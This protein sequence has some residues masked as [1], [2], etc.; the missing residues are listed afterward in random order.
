MT[1]CPIQGRERSSY[2]GPSH[3]EL[4]VSSPGSAPLRAVVPYWSP[5][6][7]TDI[8]ADSQAYSN[9]LNQIPGWGAAFCIFT[10]PPGVSV[11]AEV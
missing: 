8:E 11:D 7:G 9:L 1:R 3:P 4:Q 5:N 6:L 10:K 2:P